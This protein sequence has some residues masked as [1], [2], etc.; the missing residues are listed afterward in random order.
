M[1]E[2]REAESSREVVL[3]K[4]LHAAF[5]EV[6]SPSLF[7]TNDVSAGFHGKCRNLRI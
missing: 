7:A 4:V 1:R 6:I 2:G 3:Q 5:T